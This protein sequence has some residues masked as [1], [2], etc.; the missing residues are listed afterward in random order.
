MYFRVG[1]AT[2]A[3]K[4]NRGE[5][6]NMSVEVI[7][8][9]ENLAFKEI[10]LYEIFKLFWRSKWLILTV[11]LVSTLSMA[12]YAFLKPN[13]YSSVALLAPSEAYVGGGSL[14]LANQFGGLASLAGLNIAGTRGNKVS[15]A[16]EVLQSRSFILGFVRKRGVM[17]DL[18]AAKRWKQGSNALEYDDSVYDASTKSWASVH[19]AELKPTDEDVY[20]K[21]ISHLTVSQSKTTGLITVSLEF[22]SPVL[23]CQWL[24]WLIGDLNEKL[25]EQD[26]NDSRTTLKYLEKELSKQPVDGVQKILFQLM[27]KEMQTITLANIRDDYAFQYIDPPVVPERKSSPRR[28]VMIFAALVFG[29]IFGCFLVVLIRVFGGRESS[30]FLNEI[31]G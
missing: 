30:S 12:V 29:M 18:M 19:D 2:N 25:K 26:V 17:V 11:V 13:Q 24:E 6:L 4:T 5:P 7:P 9:H 23:A 10:G 21:F 14:A 20:E 16:L 27:E 1:G 31:E 22:I 8:S 15:I 3:K 28:A